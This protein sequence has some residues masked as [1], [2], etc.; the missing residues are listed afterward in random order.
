MLS[1]ADSFE[2]SFIVDEL[3]FARFTSPLLVI[4]VLKET[5]IRAEQAI[6]RKAFILR[7]F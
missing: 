5:G 3:S 6:H 4:L 2:L 1:K 7:S